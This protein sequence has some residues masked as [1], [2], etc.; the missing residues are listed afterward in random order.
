LKGDGNILAGILGIDRP[1]GPTSQ[2][3]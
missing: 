1:I 2:Q 3:S